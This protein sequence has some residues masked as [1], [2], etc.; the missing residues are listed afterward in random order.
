VVVWGGN[1]NRNVIPCSDFELGVTGRLGFQF[2]PQDGG[3]RY[4]YLEVVVEDGSRRFEILGGAYE[5]EPRTAI[6]IP[7]PAR[8]RH[9]D[10]DSD[11]D[12]DS[13][14]DAK[15]DPDR[16]AH[17]GPDTHTRRRSAADRAGSSGSGCDRPAAPAQ[18]AALRDTGNRTGPGAVAAPEA[19]P[20][21]VC[22]PGRSSPSRGH[23]CGYRMD[24]HA[25]APRPPGTANPCSRQ[26]RSRERP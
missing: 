3:L 17:T 2:I 1:T 15:P 23:G 9:S 16:N 4:G 20:T 22:S 18:R 10:P 19:R 12:P 14:P 26:S 21:C 5:G 24:M 7:T 13:E 8:L 6:T 11:S 25:V